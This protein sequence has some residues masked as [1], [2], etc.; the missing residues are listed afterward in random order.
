MTGLLDPPAVSFSSTSRQQTPSGPE[1]G[2]TLIVVIGLLAIISVGLTVVSPSMVRV[3]DRNSEDR[4]AHDLQLIANG[5]LAYLRQNHA[6][7]P[8][9]TSLSPDYVPLSPARMMQNARGFPRYFSVHPAI[10]GFQNST[11]LTNGEVGN[12]RFL[13]ISNLL[14]DAAPAITSTSSFEIW[15]NLDESTTPTLI[16]HRGTASSLFY[17]VSLIPKGNGASFS[18]DHQP[19]HSHGGLL[20]GHG[21]F[22]LMGTEIGLDEDNLYTTPNMVFG[23]TTNTA[24][25][26]D[27]L[28]VANKRWNPL[29]SPC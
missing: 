7:P 1:A 13:L 28:C 19:T 25:W 4:E 16:I 11:G 24:Y 5:V 12:V 21:S 18:I 2:L 9:L 17:S 22:H 15:W 6:F 23:L 20:P 27:P 3:W 10:A 26:F 8:S 29:P 14:Q